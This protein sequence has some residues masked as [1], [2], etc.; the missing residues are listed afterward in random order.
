MQAKEAKDNVRV[1]LFMAAFAFL[2]GS[3]FKRLFNI[4]IVQLFLE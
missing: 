2:V 1:P 3:L 4:E